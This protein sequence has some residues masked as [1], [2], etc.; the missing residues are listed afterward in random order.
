MDEKMENDWR[1]IDGRSSQAPHAQRFDWRRIALLENIVF[2]YCLDFYVN[3]KEEEKESLY[4]PENEG[5]GPKYKGA[6]ERTGKGNL[7]TPSKL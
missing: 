5:N 4:K 1:S 7:L 2:S 6:E 3:G